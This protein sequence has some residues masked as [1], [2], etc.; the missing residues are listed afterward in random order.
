MHLTL[1]IDVNTCTTAAPDKTH[2]FETGYICVCVVRPG[3]TDACMSPEMYASLVSRGSKYVNMRKTGD[4]QVGMVKEALQ[5]NLPPKED[6]RA[7]LP[8]PTLG[9][10]GLSLT[11]L[12]DPDLGQLLMTPER[13]VCHLGRESAQQ[14]LDDIR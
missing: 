14:I 4:N 10:A 7:R 3:H 11:T 13:L 2:R 5:K 8:W 9:I 6:T 1:T 12:V